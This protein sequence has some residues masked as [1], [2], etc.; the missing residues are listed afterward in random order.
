MTVRGADQP[1]GARLAA[2]LRRRRRPTPTAACERLIEW[3]KK[4][5]RPTVIAFFGD[6]LP[7]LGPVY[8]ET[9]FLKDQCRTAQ[10]AARRDGSSITRRRWSSGR[11]GPARSRTSAPSARRFLPL[12]CPHD[13]RHQ[14]SL[15]HRLP[16][17]DARALPCRRPQHAAVARRRCN[18]RLVA[19]RR[20]IDPA[21]RDF[22][23]LQYDMMFGKRHGR[24]T[25]S[26]RPS[27]S[28]SPIPA[29][30]AL[31]PVGCPSGT[32]ATAM[33]DKART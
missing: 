2:E 33:P 12:H 32:L 28:S 24:R 19:R 13:R 15:L 29:D 14:P 11:T 1:V 25:S 8:V 30:A 9:G 21:I 10:G 16:R 23:L 20:L 3:A 18:A 22:R 7:P 26:P 4:R 17:R 6:H 31:Y 27:T 5:E